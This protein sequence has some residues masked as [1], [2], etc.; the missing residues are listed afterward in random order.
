[1]YSMHFYVVTWA[2]ITLAKLCQQPAADPANMFQLG[3]MTGLDHHW[4]WC[5]ARLGR[6]GFKVQLQLLQ[7]WGGAINGDQLELW[8]MMS[9]GQS[10]KPLTTE[11]V[12]RAA[13]GP[14]TC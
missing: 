5:S 9:K 13:G 7:G 2:Q 3:E 1:M 10:E 11:G 6:L 14:R 4:R 12:L 8:M